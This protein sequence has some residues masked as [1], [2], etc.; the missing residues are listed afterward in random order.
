MI[1]PV[2]A[3]PA[4]HFPLAFNPPLYLFLC[5]QVLGKFPMRGS[6]GSVKQEQGQRR[7]RGQ[8]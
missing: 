6:V 3:L 8:G 2:D 7:I 5:G 4:N 1:C